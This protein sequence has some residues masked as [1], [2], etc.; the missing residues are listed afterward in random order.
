MTQGAQ[1]PKPASYEDIQAALQAQLAVFVVGLDALDPSGPTDCEGWTVADLD[2][3]MANNL[4]GLAAVQERRVD[5]APTGG[6]TAW[7]GELEAFAEVADQIARSDRLRT[8]DFVA[9]ALQALVD[10]PADTVVHQATGDH[11]LRD[12]AMFRLIEGVV[13]GLDVGIAPERSALKVVVRELAAALAEKHPG[14]SVELR[15]PPYAAVQF[16]EGPKHTRGTP[17]N[18]V[19]TDGAT[20]IRV[21]AGREAWADVVADG[22]VRA[23][24]ERS[25]LSGLLPL[26]H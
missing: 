7:A 21:V 8:K 4:K 25:D 18:V 6:V 22:R 15:I 13:H 20:F 12:A 10:H 19:E 14:H 16:V 26:L 23:S 9:P 11:A 5:T 24:G 17:P 2:N 3:H 1:V